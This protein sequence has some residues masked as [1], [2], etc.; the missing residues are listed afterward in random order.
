[1]HTVVE[2]YN[3]SETSTLNLT[4]FVVFNQ[5]AFGG[6]Y[7]QANRDFAVKKIY[8]REK[9]LADELNIPIVNISTNLESL[10]RIPGDQF[11]VYWMGIM[12]MSISKLIGTYLYSSSGGD[13]SYQVNN[14][15]LE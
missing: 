3:C 2:N 11:A 10:M 8:A 13:Y 15:H 4:H 14:S 5:G 7:Y 6:S 1:M 9:A 12:I